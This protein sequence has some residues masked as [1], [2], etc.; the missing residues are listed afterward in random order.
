MKRKILIFPDSFNPF[1]KYHKYVLDRAAHLVIPDLCV[2]AIVNDGLDSN[3]NAF[4]RKNMIEIALQ[5]Y[6][7]KFSIEDCTYD[8]V[9]AQNNKQN[10]VIEVISGGFA[11]SCDVLKYCIVDYETYKVIRGSVT[12][13]IV[14]IV[15]GSTMHDMQ[16]ELRN[17][18]IYI[19]VP[20]HIASI[21]ESKIRCIDIDYSR[22]D[23]SRDW[24]HLEQIQIDH[25]KLD[26][27]Y[28]VNKYINDHGLYA[29]HRLNMMK[30]SQKRMSHII[31]TAN[32]AKTLVKSNF[33]DP[34]ME[35]DAFVAG[36]YHDIAKEID[37]SIQAK[38][39]DDVGITGY[40][41]PN[42]LHA[43]IGSNILKTVY[44]FDNRNVLIAI[45]RHTKP[46]DYY[47]EEPDALAKVLYV[48]D[49]LEPMRNKE[50]MMGID[51]DGYRL[52]AEKNIDQCFAEGYA[53]FCRR[54]N[55]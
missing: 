9:N 55:K 14:C 31:S 17:T 26:I 40:E 25:G 46:Y 41:D 5:G 20:G 18:D 53:E 24:L 10:G 51:I 2:L 52:L 30:I 35:R 12:D 39:A 50:N 37:K 21:T 6:S 45:N 19:D 13:D 15:H 23:F 36:I 1:H 28:G 38:I 43:Y 7:R 29:I 32:Y 49:K 47:T 48:A 11:R 3:I 22:C 33:N 44:N 27:E 4:H 16:N 8:N 42:L 34:D 54:I